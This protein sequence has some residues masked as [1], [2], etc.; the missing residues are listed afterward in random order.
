MNL[1][2]QRA[3]LV[4]LLE[5]IR[6]SDR[7]TERNGANFLTNAV[8]MSDFDCGAVLRELKRAEDARNSKNASFRASFQVHF[9]HPLQGFSYGLN[10][11]TDWSLKQLDAR[12]THWYLF[13]GLDWYNITDLSKD[14]KGEDGSWLG[15]KM[16]FEY[17]ANP[18]IDKKDRYWWPLWAWILT[19]PATGN[20]ERQIRNTSVTEETAAAF[21]KKDRGG[22]LFHNRIPYLRPADKES[23]GT[24][25]PK[26]EWMKKCVRGDSIQDLELIRRL[27]EDR[28]VAFCTNEDSRKALK[29]AGFRD[30]QIYKWGAHPSRA[31]IFY[32]K[33]KEKGL[34][35]R[36]R[37]YFQPEP[38]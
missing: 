2:Y 10:P 38:V 6:R 24:D 34:W 16:W 28:T 4:P 25:W 15:N 1:D 17:L 18:F 12:P 8:P 37:D 29:A 22:F 14:L 13:L 26:S 30:D 36:G 32:A 7:Y 9:D 35:F 27:C 33:I 21:I 20:G 5:Q 23:A 19:K 11:Y 3:G 31:Y